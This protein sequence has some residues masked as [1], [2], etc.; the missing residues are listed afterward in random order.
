MK[1]SD[2]IDSHRVS[3]A[4]LLETM[5][6]A[7]AIEE[8]LRL[9]VR[10]GPMERVR[11]ELLVSNHRRFEDTPWDGR[12]SAMALDIDT[13]IWYHSILKKQGVAHD[14]G[15]YAALGLHAV[16][17]IERERKEP[18]KPVAIVVGTPQ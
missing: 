11:C 2:Y 3:A 16:R 14:V 6:S 4:L 8:Q 10:S 5:D 1:F 9:I 15:V 12:R 18:R 7:A 17:V 13:A